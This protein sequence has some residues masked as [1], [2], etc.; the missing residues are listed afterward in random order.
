VS[1]P[2]QIDAL[3]RQAERIRAYAQEMYPDAELIEVS[4]CCS[5]GNFRRRGFT[6]VLEMILAGQLS[7]GKLLCE[8]RDRLNR[9]IMGLLE[10]ICELQ[11]VEIEIIEQS[12]NAS[13][14]EL[15][16]QDLMS[17]LFLFNIKQYSSRGA[18]AREKKLSD[19]NIA[20]GKKL[21][22]AGMPI[23]QIYR[24][25]EKAEKRNEDGSPVSVHQIRKYI[26]DNKKLEQAMPKTEKTSVEMYAELGEQRPHTYR[27]VI[28]EAYQSYVRWAENKGLTVLSIRRFACQFRNPQAMLKT[29]VKTVRAWKG[30]VF[31]D[32]PHTVVGLRVGKVSVET[33]IESFMR[34]AELKRGWQG[35]LNLFT[36]EYQEWAKGEQLEVVPKIRTTT[37][38]RQMGA[39]IRRSRGY[40]DLA[41]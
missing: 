29:G 20:W 32:C 34:F 7:G 35:R 37:I 11:N 31:P 33:P 38:L 5:G 9:G 8:H 27:T 40:Y 28:G 22:N 36:K 12:D 23:Q 41:L 4:D 26:W 14:D 25:F 6:K 13:D 24:E 3:K 30:L 19:D 39:D 21:L 1:T 15:L 10:Q 18:K 16:T 2:K 17:V